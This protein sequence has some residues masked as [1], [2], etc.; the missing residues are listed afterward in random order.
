MD[1]SKSAAFA[2]SFS[3]LPKPPQLLLTSETDLEILMRRLGNDQAR[4]IILSQ[5]LPDPYAETRR[6]TRE[7][8]QAAA[9]PGKDIR[10]N[11]TSLEGY[12]S[13]KVLVEAIR[14]AGPKVSRK[15]LVTSLENLGAYDLGGYVIE[16]QPGSRLGSRFV[17]L[18]LINKNGKLTR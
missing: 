18:S 12:I 16:F 11:Y 7:Y 3:L 5:V 13:A 6:L 17:E 1:G 2:E 9:M 8:R 15:T 14:R 10:V 4:G